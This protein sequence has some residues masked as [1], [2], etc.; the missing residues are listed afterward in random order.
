MLTRDRLV[1]L[2]EQLTNDGRVMRHHADVVADGGAWV[3]TYT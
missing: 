3:D 1:E 2:G